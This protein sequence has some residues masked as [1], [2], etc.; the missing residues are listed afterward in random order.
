MSD[1]IVGIRELDDS[2]A[3]DIVDAYPASEKG[4]PC[5]ASAQYLITRVGTD[6]QYKQFIC[7]WHLSILTLARNRN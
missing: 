3:C 5:Q 7:A 1:S 4:H 2:D 6:G